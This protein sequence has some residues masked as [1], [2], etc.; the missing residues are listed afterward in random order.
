MKAHAGVW[1]QLGILGISV[2]ERQKLNAELSQSTAAGAERREK[3][4]LAMKHAKK[5]VDS[6]GIMMNQRYV[7]NAVCLEDEAPRPK[8]AGDLITEVEISTHP[9]S[10]LP[11]AWLSRK[12][13]SNT[14]STVD[15]A[16]H[17]SFLLLTGHGGDSWKSA[18]TKSE[19]ALEVPIRVVTIGWGLDYHDIYRE[20]QPRSQVE[21]GGCVLVRPDGFVAWRA[22]K[23][24]SDC[25]GRLLHVLKSILSR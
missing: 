5:E 24:I 23:M 11:H 22:K 12:V 17:G 18:A 14:I 15:L 13:P 7:S 19:S 8:F 9:G 1:E 2:E 4:G 21:D 6:L 16:S 25:E 20:W 10:R 3:L